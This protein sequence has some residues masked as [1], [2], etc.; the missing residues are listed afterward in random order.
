MQA[1]AKEIVDITTSAEPTQALLRAVK[2]AAPGAHVIY[3]R[4]WFLTDATLACAARDL[5]YQGRVDLV[6]QR[7]RAGRSG[8]FAYIAIKRRPPPAASQGI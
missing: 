1:L 4:G 5:F 2:R 8:K 6:Q 3:A 7:V